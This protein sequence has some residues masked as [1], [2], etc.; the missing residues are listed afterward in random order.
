MRIELELQEYLHC[1]LMR[2]GLKEDVQE[3]APYKSP[4][5]DHDPKYELKGEE[6]EQ[7]TPLD[8]LKLAM[9]RIMGRLRA[10]SKTPADAALL[11]EK[12]DCLVQR[13]SRATATRQGTWKT[14]LLQWLEELGEPHYQAI[15]EYGVLDDGRGHGSPLWE[16]GFWNLL[17]EVLSH[18]A[19]MKLRDL[20]TFY[21]LIPENPNA[22]EWLIFWLR[23][24]RTSSQLV[25]IRGGMQRITEKLKEAIEGKKKDRI[26]ANRRLVGIAPADDGRKVKLTFEKIDGTGKAIQGVK[27]TWLGEHV[28]LALPRGPLQDLV[29]QNAGSLYRQLDRDLASVIGFPLIKVFFSV[30]ERWWSENAAMTNRFAT[31]VPT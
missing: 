4:I 28:I 17:S 6:C 26:S 19:L 16:M 11:Q 14:I 22:A 5:S 21:H 7:E 15:R 10:E 20:G 13:L 12:L 23:G 1:V 3:F 30:K 27:E 25:G 18:H 31:L 29:H 8:L 24:L 2:L 9:L